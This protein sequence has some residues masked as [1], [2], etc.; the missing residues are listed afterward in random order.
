MRSY[1]VD[2]S[3]SVKWFLPEIHSEAARRLQ[4]PIYNLHVPAFSLLE[5][6]NILCKKVRR[7][8]LSKE[9]SETALETFRALPL[10]WYPDTD[11]LP[12]SFK[13]AHLTQRNLYDCIYLAL[14]IAIEG[15]FT[16]ADQKFCKALKKSDFR[17][18]LCWVEDI[19][20]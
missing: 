2:A 9:D 20:N 12:V 17:E 14:A 5:F 7:K 13:I 4:N 16:T 10:Q 6:T 19:P 18:Y 8:E 1:V 15:Q 11:L 3:V